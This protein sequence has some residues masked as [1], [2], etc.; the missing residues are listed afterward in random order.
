MANNQFN[1]LRELANMQMAAEAFLLIGADNGVVPG[2][3]AIRARLELG[4]THT[5]FFTP[6]QASQ[7][8]DRYQVL[9]QNRNDPL[10]AAG[11]GFSA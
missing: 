5:S 6:V 2:D 8:T 9:A 3:T 4:N 1:K 11:T 10:Q 7:L